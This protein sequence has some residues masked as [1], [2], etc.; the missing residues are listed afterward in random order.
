MLLLC[1]GTVVVIWARACPCRSQHGSDAGSV[2][3]EGNAHNNT[4]ESCTLHGPTLSLLSGSVGTAESRGGVAL[5]EGKEDE[6][7]KKLARALAAD[8]VRMQREKKK[9][10]REFVFVSGCD[11]EVPLCPS[12]PS[13]RTFSSCQALLTHAVA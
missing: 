6:S 13:P 7:A 3:S 12:P 4:S 10:A 11:E 5:G 9:Q 8:P 1:D 2:H